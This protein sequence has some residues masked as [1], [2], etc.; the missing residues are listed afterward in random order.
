ME[1]QF[2]DENATYCLNISSKDHF[3]L[4]TTFTASCSVGVLSSLA[5]IILL[6]VS[7]G[8]KEF[9]YRLFL[10]LSTAAL[11]MGTAQ[12]L[13]ATRYEYKIVESQET[14]L[15][16]FITFT[17]AYSGWIYC[18][19]LC[20]IGF[21]VFWLAM[22]HVQLKKPKHEVTGLVIV[23][24]S[25]LTV[26]WVTLWQ[27][28]EPCITK[29]TSKMVIMISANF[30]PLLSFSLFTS[31]ITVAVLII[32]CKGTCATYKSLYKKAVKETIPFA[33]FLGAHQVIIVIVFV[34]MI[35]S[36]VA[37]SEDNKSITVIYSE[38]YYLYPLLPISIPMLLV[39][40]SRLRCKTNCNC[41]RR[42]N[43]I[44]QEN[45]YKEHDPL[46]VNA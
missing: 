15:V 26:L 24:V 7:K 20:W 41:C 22:H 27:L 40:Q 23:L 37:E 13:Y 9:I 1:G 31:V 2:E 33:I 21:Y 29:S 30:L 12:M 45:I 38:L 25:P 5:A 18:L 11:V 10:Y 17:L 3:I 39:W 44:G 6:L 35:H 16:R 19:V 8:Y 42:E 46:L 43:G 4:S 28:Y 32:L 34:S 36:F 14:W